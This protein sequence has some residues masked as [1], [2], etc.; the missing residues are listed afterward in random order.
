MWQRRRLVDDFPGLIA[1][2][3]R[4][5]S[6]AFVERLRAGMEKSG[7][8]IFSS[9]PCDRDRMAFARAQATQGLLTPG[10]PAA[11]LFADYQELCRQATLDYYDRDLRLEREGCN[12]VPLANV[13]DKRKA[14]L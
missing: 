12:L 13:L 9:H 3:R 1:S 11:A 7:N 6:A 5:Y 10:L 2:L 14:G 4:G 8:R